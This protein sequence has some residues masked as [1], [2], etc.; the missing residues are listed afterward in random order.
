MPDEMENAKRFESHEMI[1]N[2]LVKPKKKQPGFTYTKST[3]VHNA[4]KWRKELE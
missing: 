4:F 1:S 2:M 3:W